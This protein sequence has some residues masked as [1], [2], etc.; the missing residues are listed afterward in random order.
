[1]A[2]NP[3]FIILTRFFLC[4]FQKNS[5]MAILAKFMKRQKKSGIMKSGL[6]ALPLFLLDDL[7][8]SFSIHDTNGFNDYE[9]IER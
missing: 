9:T 6:D 7:L 1:M 3:L 4:I 5:A 8:I 2:S